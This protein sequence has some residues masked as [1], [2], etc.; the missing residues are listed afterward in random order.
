M[1]RGRKRFLVKSER[2][3]HAGGLVPH[4]GGLVPHAGGLVPFVEGLLPHAGGLVPYVEGLVPL[5]GGLVP[6]VEGLVPRAGGLVP[7]VG[8]LVPRVGGL[9]VPVSERNSFLSYC[10]GTSSTRSRFAVSWTVGALLK[11]PRLEPRTV[12]VCY[13]PVILSPLYS[14]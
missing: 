10:L 1:E 14:I 12:R 6:Y 9:V 2:M 11:N 7:H 4:V 3:S 5:A 13:S 8:G